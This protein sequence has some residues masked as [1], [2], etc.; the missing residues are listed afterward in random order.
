MIAALD[1]AGARTV[2][3]RYAESLRQ[4]LERSGARD[5]AVLGPSPAFIHRLRGEYRWS[6]TIKTADLEP[7]LPLLP[8]GRGV[9]VDVDPL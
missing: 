6:L 3:T 2:A 4:E 8:E 5:V 1:D 9:T 7:V